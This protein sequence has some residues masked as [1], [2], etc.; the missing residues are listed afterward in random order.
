[1]LCCDF[2]IDFC[3]C[4]RLTS[5]CGSSKGKQRRIRFY[6]RCFFFA[7][8]DFWRRGWLDGILE[9]ISFLGGLIF[10]FTGNSFFSSFCSNQSTRIETH[11]LSRKKKLVVVLHQETTERERENNCE[12]NN[13]EAQARLVSRRFHSGNGKH[14]EECRANGIAVAEREFGGSPK[15]RANFCC[16][17]WHL[18]YYRSS[19]SQQQQVD[20]HPVF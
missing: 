5:H 17:C 3:C 14:V 19:C 12:E 15:S 16:C 20:E 4:D 2:V 7:F 13:P 9:E 11:N 8:P 10:G 1:L 18:R 6:K